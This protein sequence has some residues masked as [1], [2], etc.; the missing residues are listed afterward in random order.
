MKDLIFTVGKYKGATLGQIL[1]FNEGYVLWF[2]SNVIIGHDEKNKALDFI[3]S[4][5]N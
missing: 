3:H 5:R 4:K 1:D 2:L